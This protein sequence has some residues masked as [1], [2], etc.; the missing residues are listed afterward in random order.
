MKELQIDDKLNFVEEPV[1]ITDREFKQLKRRRIPIVKVRWNSKRGP[2]YTWERE[3]EIRTKYPHLF[4]D[5]TTN[6]N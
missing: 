1:E 2:E 4:S 3:D 6:S 5:I